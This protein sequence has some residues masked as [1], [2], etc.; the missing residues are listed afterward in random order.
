VAAVHSAASKALFEQQTSKLEG[1][2]LD[3][4]N[5]R[6]VE[7]AFPI[8]D[9]VFRHEGRIALRVR[10]QCDDWNEQPPSIE[11]MNEAGEFLAALPTGSNVFN[12]SSHAITHRPFICMAGAREFHTHSSH[13]TELWDNYRSRSGYDLGGILTQV[14]HA[15]LKSTP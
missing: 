6:V 11:L 2:L 4:R 13:L 14:W 9:T 12:S 8:L 10:M 3:E 15:W 5:W 7:R 1:L